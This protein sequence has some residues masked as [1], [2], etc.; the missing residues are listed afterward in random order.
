[1]AGKAGWKNDLSIALITNFNTCYHIFDLS[2]A[3]ITNF[4]TCKHIF[5]LSKA[6]IT[7]CYILCKH[8]L[9]GFQEI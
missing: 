4:N 3:P 8:L 7:K 6:P 2:I 1:M 9:D 5:D